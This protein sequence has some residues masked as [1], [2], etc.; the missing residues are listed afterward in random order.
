M[1]APTGQVLLYDAGP[2]DGNVAS[3]LR[4][5]GIEHIDLIVASHNHSDHIGGLVEVF[6]QFS[7]NFYIDNAFPH[8]TRMYER[9]WETFLE[10]GAQLLDPEPR[11]I[12]LGDVRLT[13]IPP[14]GDHGLDQNNNIVG[15][16]LDYGKFSAFFPGDAEEAQ[17]LAWLRDHPDVLTPVTLHQASHHGSRHGDIPQTI[18]AL[19]PEFVVI[20]V[21]RGNSYRHPHDEALLMYS[22]LPVYRTDLHG[23]IVVN[24]EED[25]TYTVAYETGTLDIAEN[26]PYFPGCIDINTASFEELQL[27]QQIGP[28]RAQQVIEMRAIFPF[29][30]VESLLRVRGIGAVRLGQIQDEGIACVFVE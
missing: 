15:V 12:N 7:V 13:I 22:G 27:I 18:G 1:E 11:T 23:R 10:S 16:R 5:L 4:S 9:V 14:T 6:A 30:T 21:G 2:T 29:R 24:A 3:Q 25:G 26:I 8:T 17:W 20:G 28:E 19:Q